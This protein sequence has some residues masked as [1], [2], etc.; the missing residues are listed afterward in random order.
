MS[1]PLHVTSFPQTI[2]PRLAVRAVCLMGVPAHRHR[3]LAG[4]HGRQEN[5]QIR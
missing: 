1:M 3:V 4:K 2:P 5:V